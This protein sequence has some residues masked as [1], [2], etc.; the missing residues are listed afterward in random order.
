[1]E[2]THQFLARL[3]S[4]NLKLWADGSTLRYSAPKVTLTP[5]LLTQLQGHKTEILALLREEGATRQFTPPPI[6]PV[7][8]NSE[9]PLS[10]S[11]QRLWFLEQLAPGRSTYTIAVAYRITGS[12]NLTALLQSLNALV[13]RHEI[14]RTTFPSVDG[15]PVQVI[16]PERVLTLPFIDLQEL[17]PNQRQAEVQRQVAVEAQRAFDQSQG[18]LL[19]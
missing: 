17:L 4:L 5:D 16:S 10:F 12:L 11:Q 14:L 9:I 6:S 13:Q 2:S 7:M 15:Q 1:M 3:R 19:C 8:R 18:P